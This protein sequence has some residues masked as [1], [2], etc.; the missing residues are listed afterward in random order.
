MKNP[1]AFTGK[2]EPGNHPAENSKHGGKPYLRSLVFAALLVIFAAA[3]GKAAQGISGPTVVCA[4]SSHMYN[5]TYVSGYSY[6]WSVLGAAGNSSSS[7]SLA[8]TFGQPPAS[9]AG[10]VLITLVTLDGNGQTVSTASLVVHVNPTPLPEIVTLSSMGCSA[11]PI[12]RDGAIPLIDTTVDYCYKVCDSTV[13]KY[14]VGSTFDPTH[15]YKWSVI[16][17][18][19][20]IAISA[21]ASTGEAEVYWGAPSGANSYILRLSETDPTTGCSD[22]VEICVRIIPRPQASFTTFPA[23]DPSGVVYICYNSAVAFFDQSTADPNSIIVSYLW[24]FG[25]GSYSTQQFPTHVYTTPGSYEAKLIVENQCHCKDSMTVQIEVDGQPGADIFCVS[26]VCYNT[27]DTYCANT[28]C[29]TFSWS[30]T[31]G[32]I[33][34]ATTGT[35]IDVSW[36]ANGPGSIVFTPDPSCGGCPYP[37]SVLVPILTPTTV[38]TG[39]HP[40]CENQ[41]SYYSVPNIPGT[42]YN[43]QIVPASSGTIVNGQGNH[44]VGIEFG[45]GTVNCSVQV[46][47]TNQ[48]LKCSGSAQLPVTVAPKMTVVGDSIL[49][50]GVQGN[51]TSN[52]SS[53]DWWVESTTGTTSIATGVSGASYTFP[54]AGA[55][56]IYALDQTGNY[57]ASPQA[58]QV[59]VIAQPP[60]PVASINTVICKSSVVQYVATP[61]NNNYFLNWQVT[62]GTPSQGSG[63]SISVLW[64]STGPWSMT[65]TQQQVMP[66]SCASSPLVFN[67]GPPTVPTPTINTSN[68][69]PCFNQS[70]NY[71]SAI[72]ADSYT[73]QISPSSIGSIAQ[74][75]GSGNI[76]VQ[77][78]NGATPTVAAIQLIVSIC[79]STA[80]TIYTVTVGSPATPT[81]VAP[82]LCSGQSANFST[83]PSPSGTY[84]WNFGDGGSGSGSTPAHTYLNPGPYTVSLTVTNPNGCIGTVS[85][86]SLVNVNQTPVANI[87]SPDPLQFCN[88][89]APFNFNLYASLQTLGSGATYT[90]ELNGGPIGNGGSLAINQTGIYKLLVEAN[91]CIYTTT[92][93]VADTSCTGSPTPCP[94]ANPNSTLTINYTLSCNTATFGLSNINPSGNLVKW[95][96]EPGNQS[97]TASNPVITYPASG[98][99]NA[100]V[101]YEFPKAGG[102]WCA[103]TFNTLVLVPLVGDFKYELACGTTSLDV[104]FI[105]QSNWIGS[106]PNYS[107]T[108][109]PGS[110]NSNS[111]N[112]TVPN[113]PPNTYVVTQT[114]TTGGQTCVTTKTVVVPH[115]PT[116]GFT[117][118]NSVCEGNP[119]IFVNTSSPTSEISQYLWDFGDLTSLIT[120]NPSPNG[121][122]VYQGGPTTYST[123]LNIKDIYG[124]QTVAGPVSF[125]VNLNEFL[126]SPSN[127]ASISPLL[128][129]I[130]DGGSTTF[131]ATSNNPNGPFSYMWNNFATTS[132]V[133]VGQAGVYNVV[134]TDIYGC[135]SNK[136]T[137]N[138]NVISVPPPVVFGRQ[139]YCVGEPPLL[140]INKGSGYN[141]QWIYS[142]NDPNMISSTGTYTSSSCSSPLFPPP[143]A[144]C[145]LSPSLNAGATGTLALTGLITETSSGLNCQA[146]WGAV[147]LTIHPL[148]PPPTV[149]S[150]TCE[151]GGLIPLTATPG[152]TG[153]VNI[154]WNTG[155]QGSPINVISAGTYWASVV[156]NHGCV[157]EPDTAHIWPLPDFSSVI[158]GCYEICD[159]G[160][161]IVP[162]PNEGM[163]YPYASYTWLHNGSVVA[164]PNSFNTPLVL[165]PPG[166]GGTYELILTTTHGC[167][168]TSKTIEF[169]EKPCP[170]CDADQYTI[171]LDNIVCVYDPVTGAPSYNFQITMNAP[172]SSNF[173]LTSGTGNLNLSPAVSWFNTGSNVLTGNFIPVLGATKLCMHFDIQINFE[174][175]ATCGLDVCFDLPACDPDFPPCQLEGTDLQT[176]CLGVNNGIATYGYNLD[177]IYSGTSGTVSLSSA[178]GFMDQSTNSASNGWNNITGTFTDTPSP[179][180]VVCFDIIIQWLNDD[181]EYEWC[182]DQV[183]VKLDPTP[184]CQPTL[185]DCQFDVNPHSSVCYYKN[186][187]GQIV[188]KLSYDINNTGT[189]T[190]SFY[191][192]SSNGI[193][194]APAPGSIPPSA[195]TTFTQSFVEI[196]STTPQ[197]FTL[198][199]T[200]LGNGKECQWE[201]CFDPEPCNPD[202]LRLMS[203]AEVNLYPN[204]TEDYTIAEY[205]L[206][207]PGQPNRL[208][209]MDLNGRIVWEAT[210]TETKGKFEINTST[211][212]AGMYF[213]KAINGNQTVLVKK[214]IIQR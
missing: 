58:H 175:P 130:C 110:Y 2:R 121:V 8:V 94:L 61:T 91:G 170:L 33:T 70:V 120:Q 30:V 127:S 95:V 181:G 190:Y 178:Q 198:V 104:T 129:Q 166:V 207:N 6:V 79:G 74:G 156:D 42:A 90:W 14:Q 162:V 146:Q 214:L 144:S 160:T 125:T 93:L 164:G 124:C 192:M 26:P 48:F 69:T 126:A 40:A 202:Q 24:D 7:N 111:Q 177:F 204:P 136:P 186:G 211:L 63:N 45:A 180:G 185:P 3:G 18:S 188:Y 151:S 1:S 133:A 66:P 196:T 47:Y 157:S 12:E 113:M 128:S 34:S 165:N 191:V 135:K 49:C 176:W 173:T 106:T 209:L 31:N 194:G 210:T 200:D 73:W 103:V 206:D 22:S 41:V 83:S 205:V 138:L 116:A 161:V 112:Y 96:F 155:Q 52:S 168:D 10:N 212:E 189:S 20:A 105:D 36:G 44:Q 60:A 167:T 17:A 171:Q 100:W 86:S 27:S 102:G 99:Y 174:G 72:S 50:A 51:Y 123:F 68:S 158:Y 148:P 71:S 80:S 153:A 16:P 78:N 92:V 89:G 117:A 57:C 25:D 154:I 101:T 23:A 114:A 109:T 32:T 141:Y 199:A 46:V 213:L 107:W 149:G 201:F 35:C 77:Y 5:V 187:N 87:T 97:S 56:V 11:P 143:P 182:K 82:S 76:T 64:G 98:Y 55:Y 21:T 53:A 88:P 179:D 147:T 4:N 193:M 195:N 184:P 159:T 142:T 29:S 75:A 183:C 37:S 67:L 145:A 140:S 139:S 118:T 65:L 59:Q 131:C 172:T 19:A 85:T 132:C 197:C 13:F 39:P 28:S 137:V 134:L 203:T 119:V 54:G 84:A 81:I 43:W 152:G 163:F 169:T 62:G 150:N 9:S 115:K 208:C 15:N 108:T 38:V 122:K